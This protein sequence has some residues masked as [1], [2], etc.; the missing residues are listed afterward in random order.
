[1]K[2]L[3]ITLIWIAI[4]A[5]TKPII[6]AN[7]LLKNSH[8]ENFLEFYENDLFQL[9]E[10]FCEKFKNKSENLLT[11]KEIQEASTNELKE[12]KSFLNIYL[13]DYPHYK[14]FKLQNI[15]LMTLF[16]LQDIK[17]NVVEKDP[18]MVI[19]FKELFNSYY[20]TLLRE[21]V[22]NYAK[23]IRGKFLK[24][25]ED[26][27]KRLNSEELRELN[28]FIDIIKSCQNYECLSTY[29]EAIVIKLE[30]TNKVEI[31]YFV[32]NYKQYATLV[33]MHYNTVG[34]KIFKN[35]KLYKL[36]LETR[37]NLISD[38]N[39]FKAKFENTDDI[40]T[41][42]N[43]ITIK[44][45]F[46]LK[47]LNNS[48]IPLKDHEIFH[49][50]ME[51]CLVDFAE[52]IYEMQSYLTMFFVALKTSAMSMYLGGNQSDDIQCIKEYVKTLL[53]AENIR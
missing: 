32:R 12:F 16:K 3:I 11:T 24:K 2:I 21:Y 46:P 18:E 42:V 43:S 45:S 48:N 51:E 52:S 13:Q 6:L 19:K 8:K 39:D 10:N 4:Q 47:Y 28:N 41:F 20:G 40:E 53:Q 50:V 33:V 34:Q 15:L 35:K 5:G 49:D 29:L 30:L 17:G 9:D 14:R 38:I 1:M 36:S 26:I 22:E 31:K 25:V 44:P 27:K 37:N 7:P 23:L